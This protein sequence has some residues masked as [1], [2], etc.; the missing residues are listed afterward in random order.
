MQMGGLPNTSLDRKAVS[1]IVLK[2]EGG[3]PMLVAAKIHCANIIAGGV[4][5][6]LLVGVS[7]TYPGS[8]D[9]TQVRDLTHLCYIVLSHIISNAYT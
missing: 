8:S 5:V 1:R 4:I 2:I 7:A 3:K 9:L 6:I